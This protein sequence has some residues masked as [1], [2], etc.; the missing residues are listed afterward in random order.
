MR[1][2]DSPERFI[3]MVRTAL[4]EC[5]VRTTDL[6]V[7]AVSGGSDSLSLLR[8]LH[9]L[10]DKD[11]PRLHCAHLDHGL[12]G[13]A[14]TADAAFVADQCHSLG[15]PL[16][17]EA[18]DVE[19]VRALRRLSVEAAAREVRYEFLSRVV[20]AQ[21][22]RAV[23]LGHTADDQ[24]ETILMNIVRG[25]GLAGL[26]GMRPSSMRKIDGVDLLLLRPL[27][28]IGKQDTLDFCSAL[29]LEPRLDASNLSPAATRNM[30]RLEAIPLLERLNPA[31]RE[32]LLRLSRSATQGVAHLDREA[33]EAWDEMARHALG[34]VTLPKAPLAAMD[35]AVRAHL[36]RRAVLETK[37]D[38]DRL[39]QG[40]IEQIAQLATGPAGRS[41]DLPGGLLFSVAYEDVTFAVGRTV[42]VPATIDGSLDIAVPGETRVE[43]WN[44]SAKLM[45]RIEW[46]GAAEKPARDTNVAYLS[47]PAMRDVQVRSRRAGDRFQP[48]GLSGH[49]KL[50]DFMVDSHVPREMRDATPLVVAGRRI[51]WVVGWR[52]AEWARVTEDDD[53]VLELKFSLAQS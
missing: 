30:L 29:G 36:L 28:A 40:H 35:P 50:Q 17:S 25:S 47:P 2:A 6:L 52:I 34:V 51:A 8:A 15:I 39:D 18:V 38:L 33:D 48:L 16:T 53:T 3:E 12:R 49:K 4:D 10:S 46:E 27:L 37:G 21:G 32:A 26:Q 42:P 45:N 13:A 20:R 31:V 23:V 11:G 5:G 41:L 9:R 22:A 14:S 24:A 7:V 43:P 1:T 19:E 44:I